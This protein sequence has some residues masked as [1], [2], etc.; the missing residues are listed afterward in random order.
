RDSI[1]ITGMG[2]LTPL[3][4]PGAWGGAGGGGGAEGTFA[5]ICAGQ[6]IQN[7]G[8]IDPRLLSQTAD[9]QV[10]RNCGDPYL[11]QRAQTMLADPAWDKAIPMGLHVAGQALEQA[12]W[13][14]TLWQDPATSFFVGTSKGPVR[15]WLQSLSDLRR[16]GQLSPTQARQIAHGPSVIAEVI[17]EIL[18]MGA[19][20]GRNGGTSGGGKWGG[21]V[22]T[23]VAACSS[24]MHALHRAARALIRGECRRALV[25]AS[26]ASA[27]PF[28]EASFVNL[29]VLAP[30]GADGHRHCHPLAEPFD[31]TRAGFILSEGAAAVVLELASDVVARHPGYAPRTWVELEQTWIGAD[32]TNLVA[33]DAQTTALRHGLRAVLR[34]GNAG[35]SGADAL[36]GGSVWPAGHDTDGGVGTTLL[37]TPVDFV[38]AHATGTA[39]DQHELEAIRTVL[40]NAHVERPGQHLSDALPVVFSHKRHLGHSL[41]AAGL[42]SVVLSAFCHQAGHTYGGTPLHGAAGERAGRSI[43]ISQGFGGHIGL[44]VLRG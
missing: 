20:G 22:H 25:I 37:G 7:R 17:G 13:P 36:G 41:G 6:A 29:G 44:A 35:N 16:T 2:L 24:G 18:G 27:D 9:L 42:T 15:T 14:A 1:L 5:A 19:G 40:P 30:R 26:D 12:E 28:F 38:H 23:S 39:H 4:A 8:I 33:M 3:S 21:Q 43:S 34:N 10:W 31:K 11:R 32:G